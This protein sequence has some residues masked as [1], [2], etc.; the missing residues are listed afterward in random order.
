MKNGI[1]LSDFYETEMDGRT[2]VIAI[3]TL[4]R[5]VFGVLEVLGGP[6][7]SGQKL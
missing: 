7:I 4:I 2:T 5:S 3:C 6:N 1:F